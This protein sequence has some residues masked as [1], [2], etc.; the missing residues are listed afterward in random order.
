MNNGF[1]QGV[2]IPMGNTNNGSSFI[3]NIPK[4]KASIVGYVGA[5]IAIIANFLDFVVVKAT[6]GG[7]SA[8]SSFSYVSTSSGKFV[9]ILFVATAVLI[10]L[11]KHVYSAFTAGTAA[12]VFIYN[13]ATVKEKSSTLTYSY[14][15]VHWGPG[16]WLTIVGL[17]LIAASIYLYWK[18]NPDCFKKLRNSNNA[19][20]PQPIMNNFGTPVQNTQVN[21]FGQQPVNNIPTNN[22]GQQPIN[23]IPTN[24]F[25][26][27]TPNT[28]VNNFVQPTQNVAEQNNQINNG[29]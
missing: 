22:F 15:K 14:V 17:V 25:G 16:I 3:D 2:N 13:L 4:D 21:N 24:N 11:K 28:Q 7:Y 12:I 20:A 10:A 8:S 23:N 29:Q 18:E 27:Q 9:L 6:L 5:L 26:Q 1:N 19:P